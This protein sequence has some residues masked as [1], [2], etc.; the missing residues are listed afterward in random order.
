MAKS[1][2]EN[3]SSAMI[4]GVGTHPNYR[5]LGLATKCVVKICC[6]LLEENKIPC[7]FYDNE[8][9]GYIYDKLGFK[10]LGSWSIHYKRKR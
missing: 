6:E 4:V 3:R 9:A 5:N 8:K 7:L 2:G 1:T 10:Q